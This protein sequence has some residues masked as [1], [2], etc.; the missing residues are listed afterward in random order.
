MLSC[1]KYD[2]RNDLL[3]NTII[4]NGTTISVGIK[5]LNEVST[6]AKKATTQSFEKNP[7]KKINSALETKS[8][9][10]MADLFLHLHSF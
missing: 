3:I 5:K 6:V 9:S 7:G 2:H 10:I 1:L 4:P 8:Q